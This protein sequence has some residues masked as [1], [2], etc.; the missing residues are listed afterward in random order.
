MNKLL[1]LLF[2]FTLPFASLSIAG[3]KMSPET[4][5]GATTVDATQAKALF[6]K[7]VL[8]VDVRKDKDWDAGRIPDA[9]HLNVKTKFSSDSLL[10]EMKKSDEVVMYCN[11][12][13]CMRSSKA[14]AKAVE[15]GFTNV[16]YFRDG[17]PGWKA[18]GY[19][20]E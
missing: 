14:S 11:G 17:L 12:H 8:F 2:I 1:S 7:G 10:G 5:S 4:I 18:A 16:K 13:K 19:P 20:V 6:D 3:D 15:W 9:V